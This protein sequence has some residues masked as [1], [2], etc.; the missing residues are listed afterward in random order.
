MNYPMNYSMIKTLVLK[1][2]YFNR[3][4]ISAYTGGALL[5]LGIVLLDT[6]WSFYVATVLIITFM[7]TIGIHLAMVTVV[8]ER[9]DQTLPFVMSLPISPKEYTAAKI[10]ANLSIFLVPW[11]MLTIGAALILGTE[12]ARSGAMIPFATIVLTYI[13][14]SYT[15]VLTVAV[16]TESQGWTLTVM[17]VT[18]LFL[19]FF[20]YWV[21]HLPS[22]SRGMKGVGAV[23][24]RTAITLLGGLILLSIVSIALAFLFQARKRD[25]L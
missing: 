4:A 5:G 2:W 17:G 11:L 1:D 10:L 25:F 6:G 18:N 3:R 22:I 16:V 8:Q 23:W 9:T 12:G 19:Q 13:L 7:I 20:L 21:S 15:V 24:D 14:A